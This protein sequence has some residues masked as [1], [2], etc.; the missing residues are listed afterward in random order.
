[1]RLGQDF[2]D[3]AQQHQTVV[4]REDSSRGRRLGSTPLFFRQ[5]AGLIYLAHRFHEKNLPVVGNRMRTRSGCDF[6]KS[7]PFPRDDFGE[8]FHAFFPRRRSVA[9]LSVLEKDPSLFARR[10]GELDRS[11]RAA[12][13][14]QLNDVGD[15]QIT[16]RSLKLFAVR[17]TR[18]M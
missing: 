10:T 9:D 4:D 15:M 7:S 1:M 11:C 13:T 14:L 17:F 3:E 2:L 6:G 16:Q 8:R 5:C 12:H 18:R